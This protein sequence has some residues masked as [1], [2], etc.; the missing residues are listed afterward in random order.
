MQPQLLGP[1]DLSQPGL[2][3]EPLAGTIH[4]TRVWGVVQARRA[5][6]ERATPA[7]DRHPP[8]RLGRMVRIELRTYVG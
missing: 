7:T 8:V 4:L 6:G 5:V 1:V 2:G 3:R